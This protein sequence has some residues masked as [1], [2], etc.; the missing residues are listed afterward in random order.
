M[1]TLI[2]LFI[3]IFLLGINST[4]VLAETEEELISSSYKLSDDWETSKDLGEQLKENENIKG[5]ILFAKKNSVD[6]SQILIFGRELRSFYPIEYFYGKESDNSFISYYNLK[7]PN[8]ISKPIT[9]KNG[10]K[11][12]QTDVQ[13]INAKQAIFKRGIWLYYPTSLIFKKKTLF[14]NYIFMIMFRSDSFSNNNK[15][16]QDFMKWSSNISLNLNL[17]EE[18]SP[19]V[20]DYIK[21][22]VLNNYNLVSKI[23]HKA[24]QKTKETQEKKDS[25]KEQKPYK[26]IINPEN[27]IL[28]KWFAPNDVLKVSEFRGE[29]VK[30]GTMVYDLE[31][32]AFR[33]L[34]KKKEINV[35]AEPGTEMITKNEPKNDYIYIKNLIRIKKGKKETLFSTK[36][37]LKLIKTDNTAIKIIFKNIKYLG[38]LKYLEEYINK[39]RKIN[40]IL[41]GRSIDLL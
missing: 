23:S 37:Y 21:E 20:I 18:V 5:N 31:K 2:N 33:I 7:K 28:A 3:I 9:L 6:N 14:T 25:V 36:Y 39:I 13:N 24:V 41:Y 40:S 34:Y 38:G 16:Y 15:S 29:K 17:V 26:G 11:L 30:D 4:I 1:K 19:D 10:I 27:L 35:T 22:Y 12:A 8:I 32:N